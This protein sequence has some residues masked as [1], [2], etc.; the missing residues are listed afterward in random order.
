M[1]RKGK[2]KQKATKET[3]ERPKR[4]RRYEYF[5]LIVCEDQKT[6]PEY[7]QQFVDLFPDGTLYLKPVGTGLSPLGVV[8]RAIIEKAEL[9]AESKKEFGR[10][11]AVWV[12]F[13]KDDADLN[14]TTRRNFDEAFEIANQN[15]FE[16]AYSNE[17]FEL[18][19]LLHLEEVPSHPPIP[20]SDIYTRLGE[21][22]RQNPNESN[23]VY[24]HGNIEIVEKINQFGNELNA[25]KR[26]E[27]LL[28][29]QKGV[30]PIQAN[31]STKVHL[32]VQELRVWIDYYNPDRTTE[33]GLINKS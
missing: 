32:L 28:Q 1:A 14:D 21:L 27:I 11:D 23:F 17:A 19:F 18:W 26:A 24:D 6:E 16:I 5:F 10:D 25:I 20:R 15:K 13:D 8:N 4:V 3:I 9:E 22:I 2:L 30:A 29:A 31:P 12:V 33:T 7:F